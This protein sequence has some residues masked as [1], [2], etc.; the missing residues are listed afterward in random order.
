MCIITW[1]KLRSKQNKER[2]IPRDLWNEKRLHSLLNI[3]IGADCAADPSRTSEILVSV[4]SVWGSMRENDLL[5]DSEKRA[6]K[7]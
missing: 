7:K 1:Q 5:W 2:C 4:E 3:I 6:G